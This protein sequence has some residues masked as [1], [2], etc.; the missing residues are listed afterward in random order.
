MSEHRAL[1]EFANVSERRALLEIA[2][3]YE[4]ALLEIANVNVLHVV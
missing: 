4:R 2:N 3:V 1:L